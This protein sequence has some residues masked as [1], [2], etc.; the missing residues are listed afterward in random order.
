MTPSMPLF[1]NKSRKGS[2]RCPSRPLRVSDRIRGRRGRRPPAPGMRRC[3]PAGSATQRLLRGEFGAAGCAGKVA[4]LGCGVLVECEVAG[5]RALHGVDS[6]WAGFDVDAHRRWVIMSLG[7][8]RTVCRRCRM[9]APARN[10]GELPGG[11]VEFSPGSRSRIRRIGGGVGLRHC[12]GVVVR[13]GRRRVRIRR[14]RHT[15]RVV[16]SR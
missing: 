6:T 12:F 16:G 8:V 14:G 1:W 2:V 11:T 3:P 10:V 13:L 7:V 4:E 15:V 5:G 9:R